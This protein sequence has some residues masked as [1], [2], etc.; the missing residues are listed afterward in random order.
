MNSTENTVSN[1]SSS[2][3]PIKSNNMKYVTNMSDPINARIK[4]NNLTLKNS[5]LWRR[6]NKRVY[7]MSS[8]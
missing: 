3:T 4:E 7:P 1:N 8:K 2:V 6:R 5:Q